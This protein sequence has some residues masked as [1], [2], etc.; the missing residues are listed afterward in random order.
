MAVLR[1]IRFRGDAALPRPG[2]LLTFLQHINGNGTGE[3][4]A[5]DD[6]HPAQRVRLP[7]SDAP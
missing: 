3:D 6:A 1:G 4:G 5:P 2:W 7:E